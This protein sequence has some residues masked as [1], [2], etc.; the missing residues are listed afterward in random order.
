MEFSRK[1]RIISLGLNNVAVYST[2]PI[3]IITNRN[4]G[5]KLK[6]QNILF[7]LFDCAT[8]GEIITVD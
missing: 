8:I 1:V 5:V 3:R 2:K 4:E 7:A 6:S